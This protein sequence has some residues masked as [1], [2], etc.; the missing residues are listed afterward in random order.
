MSAQLQC[1]QR[2]T[3]ART[4]RDYTMPRA[5]GDH[6]P[7]PTPPILTPHRLLPEMGL[8]WEKAL[9]GSCLTNRRRSGR[10]PENSTCH[11]LRPTQPCA[12]GGQRLAG[13]T[14]QCRAGLQA[15]R[16]HHA[17]HTLQFLHAEVPGCPATPVVPN[18]ICSLCVSVTV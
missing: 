11:A 6:S 7:P 18:S 5:P 8:Y 10:D 1:P 16:P 12:G 13:R 2:H 17:S 3:T 9:Q 4:R 14:Y 15:Q